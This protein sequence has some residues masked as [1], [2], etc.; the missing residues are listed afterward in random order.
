MV[1]LKV[2]RMPVLED[3]TGLKKSKLYELMRDGLF[4][5]PIILH[6]RSRG[7]LEGEINNWLAERIAERDSKQ[8]LDAVKLSTNS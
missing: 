7:W 5:K 8:N 2:I 3:T 6:G 4:P 1:K